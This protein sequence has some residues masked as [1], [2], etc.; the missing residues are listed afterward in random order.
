MFPKETHI[1]IVDD[2]MTMRKLVK[3]SLS[4]LGFTKIVEAENGTVALDKFKLMNSSNTPFQ[5]VIS[6]WNMPSM[7]GIELLKSIR[8]LPQNGEVPFVLLT[9]ESEKG[10][11]LQAVQARVSG[12]LVKP[13]TSQMIQEKL[14]AIHQTLT[15][16]KA[17]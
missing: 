11:I 12:Y 8:S 5:L 10:Q 14:I 15:S 13:F 3:K 16:K 17:A 7:T 4:D 2:M 1:L 9:A 6:D